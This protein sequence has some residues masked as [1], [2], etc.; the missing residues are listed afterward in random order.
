MPTGTV[1]YLT[2]APTAVGGADETTYFPIE[3]DNDGLLPGTNVL[4]VEIHQ[5]SIGSSDVSFDLELIGLVG[6]VH[7]RLWIQPNGNSHILRWPSSAAG[8]RLQSSTDLRSPANWQDQ[9][10]APAD[11]WAWRTLTLPTSGAARFYRLSQ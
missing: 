4:A 9:P 2:P 7:P 3:I 11:D 6:E 10:G 8:F 1:N 5:Q